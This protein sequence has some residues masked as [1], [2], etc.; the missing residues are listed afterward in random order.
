MSLGLEIA[1]ASRGHKSVAEVHLVGTRSLTEEDAQAYLEDDSRKI[2]IAQTRL[3]KIRARHHEAA[4]LMASGKN[5][6]E[7]HILTGLAYSTLS[8]LRNDPAFADLVAHYNKIADEKFETTHERLAA[9]GTDAIE[10]LQERLEET[11]EEFDNDQLITVIKT[12]SD[13]TGY[14]PS[15]KQQVNVNVNLADKLQRAR[16]AMATRRTIELGDD[17]VK[18]LG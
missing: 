13:R 18:K 3:K 15:S 8:I 14:G 6:A 5:D 10:V 12:T 1:R 11:P 7:I 9:L 17:D 16:E 2:P 4:R